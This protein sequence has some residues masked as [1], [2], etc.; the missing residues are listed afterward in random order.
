[1]D[2]TLLL[3]IGRRIQRRRKQQGL[4]Q[5][6]LA[7]RMNVSVQMVSNL[8]RGNK[9]I[10]IDNL[11][12]LCGILDVSTDYIL[13]GRGTQTDLL[14]LAARIEHLPDP[15]RQ[16]IE[17]LVVFCLSQAIETAEAADT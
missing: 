6:Q 4:T 1:M 2:N 7:D 5:E 15:N 11:I 8:E 3:E 14:S 13:T 10:R 9:A 16:M 12:N 17:L